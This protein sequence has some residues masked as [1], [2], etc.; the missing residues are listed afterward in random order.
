V[1]DGEKNLA[2]SGVK[3]D[4]RFAF[5]KLTTAGDKDGRSVRLGK[6]FSLGR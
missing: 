3:A 2:L 6:V 5:F 4:N 1:G